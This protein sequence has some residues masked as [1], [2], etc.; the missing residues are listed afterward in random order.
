MQVAETC[1]QVMGLKSGGLYRQECMDSL[2][3]S[4]AAEAQGAQ[5]A[6]SYGLCSR[7]GLPEGTAAFSTCMLDNQERAGTVSLEPTKLAYGNNSQNSKSY[8]HV[9]NGE[10]WRREQYACA[11]LGLMPGTAP[12][13]HCVA[14]LDAALSPSS[15]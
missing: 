15:F 4:L 1:D 13:G 6:A 8:F 14:S 9:S 11:Q 5:I 7:Q 3:R 12:F 10:H 2:A